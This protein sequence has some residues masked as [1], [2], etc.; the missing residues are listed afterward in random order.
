L[1]VAAETTGIRLKSAVLRNFIL[2][3][4]KFGP[5]SLLLSLLSGTKQTQT[6]SAGLFYND[7]NVY[8][9]CGLRFSPL[10]TLA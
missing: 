7:C 4:R 9:D 5:V 1:E 6:L 2:I 10:I 8:A 3:L